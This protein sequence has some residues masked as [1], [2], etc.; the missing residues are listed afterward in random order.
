M[1]SRGIIKPVC[2]GRV[3]SNSQTEDWSDIISSLKDTNNVQAAGM[4]KYVSLKN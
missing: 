1:S 3:F 2:L 4:W